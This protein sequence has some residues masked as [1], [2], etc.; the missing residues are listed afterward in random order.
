MLVKEQFGYF[1]VKAVANVLHSAV[2]NFSLMQCNIHST[3]WHAGNLWHCVLCPEMDGIIF[4]TDTSCSQDSFHRHK[5][6]FIGV[7]TTDLSFTGKT[8]GL[9]LHFITT[10][11]PER[12]EQPEGFSMLPFT[13]FSSTTSSG[14]YV[15]DVDLTQSTA[16][17]GDKIW[18]KEEP[19]D[20]A[21]EQMLNNT[22]D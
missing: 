15:Q 19:T 5:E 16:P 7:G 18:I 17:H 4:S 6:A 2:R 9:D 20:E 10:D 22:G 1:K 12:F 8:E 21:Y 11:Q 14:L 13:K 3:L